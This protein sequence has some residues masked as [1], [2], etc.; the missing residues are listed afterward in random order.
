[1]SAFEHGRHEIWNP[2]QHPLK[3][4]ISDFAYTHIAIP[5]VTNLNA[6]LDYIFN[7]IYPRSQAAVDTPA[8]LPATLNTIGDYRVVTDDGDGKAAGYQWQQREGDAAAKWY[9]I[10]DLDWGSDDVLSGFIR[11]T[12]DMYVY[13]YG[14]DDTDDTGALLTGDNKGQHV[15]G[16]AT[17]NGH[18]TLHANS[19]DGTGAATGFIQFADQVRPFADSTYSLGTTTYRWLKIW[20]DEITSGTL[21]A[22][23]GSITDSSGAI[24]FD[25]ENLSTTG[26]LTSGT[27]TVGNMV[28]ASA[29]IT[30]T[31]GAISFNDENLSTTG[32]LVSG[33]HTVSADLVLA[34]GSITSASGTI[35]FND[36]NLS[37]S[38]TLA[39]GNA[40]V[41]RL[42]SDNVRIDLNTI[43]VLNSGGNLNLSANGAGVVNV[44]SAMTTIGQTVT[45]TLA[46]TGLITIDNLSL[47]GNTLASTD[48]NGN[49]ALAP[50][51]SGVVTTSGKI[52]PTADG[53]KDL[54]S[55]SARFQNV[56]FSGSLGDG[57]TTIAQSVLQS[58]RD[59]NVG[60]GSGYTIFW[61][62]SKWVASVPDT[63]VDHGSISGLGDDDHTQYL[64]LLGRS[65]GQSIIG[66]TASGNNLTLESTS[67][68][69]K[70]KILT[71]D[72]FA[73]N[74]DASY[75]GG[76]S[77]TD[78]GG[79]SN[80]F[81]DVYTAG[82]H[83][84]LRLENLSSDP[85]SSSQRTGRLFFDTVLK[86][87]KV[88]T[89]SAISLVGGS[90]SETDTSWDGSTALKDVTV[91]DI[92]ATHAIWALHDNTNNYERMYVSVKAT[93]T[94]NV[95]ITT[96]VS[97]PA[98]TYR[99]IGLQ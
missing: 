31:S 33:T 50:N 40:T 26:T 91:S 4:K 17:A 90:R 43:S 70:G 23:D 77:G 66:G 13:R 58:L 61:N 56:Y 80:R 53:T 30:N 11:K 64:L 18:L 83:F 21:T 1:M 87:V 94:T 59:I 49:I 81:R 46:V 14:Y 73:A 98:G 20:T 79:S 89:G 8:D 7:V 9:K 27:H 65:G 68:A 29:S 52:L 15:Y 99:L 82:E 39:A 28:L 69:S 92:D 25:N 74:T 85:S 36:E 84:G 76:W 12:Q 71:K 88:D 42:D 78:L 2:A 57:T 93:S 63:E 5:G 62:G 32:T 72:T 6:A 55:T 47:D 37:T 48:T 60:V 96:N 24:S 35:S 97:L 10:Y 51:G 38:G 86:K 19:G 22:K 45:G 16:G 75:S 44:S 54:G 67:N 3:H 41:T 95:R 34:T